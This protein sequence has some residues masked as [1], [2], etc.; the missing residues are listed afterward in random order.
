[1]MRIPLHRKDGSVVAHALVDDEDAHLAARPWHVT[2]K[3]YVA[4][5]PRVG[6]PDLSRRLHRI[7]MNMGKDDDREVD[8]VNGDRLDCRRSNLRHATRAM[9]G[10]NVASH[11]GSTSPLR[12]VSW[13]AEKGRWRATGFVAGRQHHLGYFTDEEKA[14]AVAAAW[15]LANMPFT[16]EDRKSRTEDA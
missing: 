5:S 16:N 1:M 4:C 12:G 2:D 11:T 7:V 15:R 9:N 3:G 13:N 8:H 14:G 10:Q 6:E